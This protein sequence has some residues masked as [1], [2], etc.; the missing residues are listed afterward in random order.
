MSTAE[1]WGTRGTTGVSFAATLQFDAV[2]VRLGG[3]VVLDQ[4][5]LTLRPGEIVCLLGESGSG[6][7]TALR[8]AAGIQPVHGG[9]V[10]INGDTVSTPTATVPPDR[11]GIGLMFQDFALF[12]HLTVLQNVL[13]GLKKLGRAAALGQAEAALRRVGLSERGGD[14]PH[15]LS[16]GQQQRLA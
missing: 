5:S 1:H 4:F 12:P 9:A 3:R 2:D 16:G 10:R 8:V 13:F 6:K 15:M 14:Y 11:R 7:S